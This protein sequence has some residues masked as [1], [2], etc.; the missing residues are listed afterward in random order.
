MVNKIKVA[1]PTQQQIDYED[2]KKDFRIATAKARLDS[3]GINPSKISQQVIDKVMRVFD[4]MEHV[5]QDTQQKIS[6]LQQLTETSIQKVNQ[7]ANQKYGEIQ[8]RYQDLINSLRGNNK[9]DISQV[10]ITQVE[11]GEVVTQTESTKEEVREKSHEEMVAEI[12][13]VILKYMRDSVSERVSDIL[14]T[15]DKKTV[16]IANNPGDEEQKIDAQNVQDVQA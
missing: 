11:A 5:Q 1:M 10:G 14:S 4:D 6:K 15:A 3:A 8:K 16:E 2:A 9:E 12:T 7:D 13:D